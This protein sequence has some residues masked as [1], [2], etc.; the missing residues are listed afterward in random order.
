MNTH[1]QTLRRHAARR[2]LARARFFL[3]RGVPPSDIAERHSKGIYYQIAMAM[4]RKRHTL[5]LPPPP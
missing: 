5:V 3:P 2:A 4:F 1:D